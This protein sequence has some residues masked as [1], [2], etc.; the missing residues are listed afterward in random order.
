MPTPRSAVFLALLVAGCVLVVTPAAAAAAS[1]TPTRTHATRGEPSPVP[2]IDEDGDLVTDLDLRSEQVAPGVT[3]ETFRRIEG[4]EQVQVSILRADLSL[5]GVRAGLLY[6]GTVA[7]RKPLSALATQAGAVGGI[8]GDF[9]DIGRSNAP[10]GLAIDDGELLKSPDNIRPSAGVTTEGRGVLGVPSFQGSVSLPGAQFRLDGVNRY[11]LPPDG[12][13]L[14]TSRWGRS[15]NQPAE[16]GGPVTSVVVRGGLVESVVAGSRSAPVPTD[17]FELLGRGSAAGRLAALTPGSAVSSSLRAQLSPAPEAPL[18][19]ALGGFVFLVRDGV[20]VAPDQLNPF[21]PRAAVGFGVGGRTMVL[22]TIDGRQG[23]ST[24]LTETRDFAQL[25]RDVGAVDALHLDG[26][27]ST[28]MV[29]RRPGQSSAQVVNSPSDGAEVTGIG[30][31]ERPVP[32]GV[33][34]FVDPGPAPVVPEV[35]AAPLLPAAGAAVLLSVVAVARR[36]LGR[37]T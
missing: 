14:Y 17:G 30:G 29:L 35:P 11:S 31:I 7:S 19:L 34:I 28:T 32:N 4:A 13:G 10:Y 22:V 16:G 18:D 24:G 5:P 21:Y 25:V 37:H 6:P 9:F 1:A 26:G 3:Y 23:R 27:G 12:V 2:R 8:N 36:R 20:I 15:R 33:G